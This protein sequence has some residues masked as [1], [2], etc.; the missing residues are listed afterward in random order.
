MAAE[1]LIV[2]VVTPHCVISPG[3]KDAHSVIQWGRLYLC[4]IIAFAY[5]RVLLR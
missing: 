3:A 2:Y 5:I 4:R 1:L